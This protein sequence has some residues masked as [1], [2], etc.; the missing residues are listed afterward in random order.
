MNPNIGE[1][2]IHLAKENQLMGAIAGLIVSAIGFVTAKV[3]HN[4][5]ELLKAAAKQKEQSDSIKRST[6]RAE[7]LS[8]YNSDKLT[9]EEKYRIT[10]II[11]ADYKKY[12]GNHYIDELDSKLIRE[13]ESSKE[14]DYA[15]KE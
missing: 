8:V 6:L 14:V 10:R 2:L 13:Y 3:R 1:L 15:K 7:Y 9:L 5:K 12:K 4:Q 11:Y